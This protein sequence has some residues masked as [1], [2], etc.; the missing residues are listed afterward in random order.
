MADLGADLMALGMDLGADLA[1]IWRILL[2]DVEGRPWRATPRWDS[3][4]GTRE[5]II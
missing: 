4:Q 5:T 1:R 3:T 2:A